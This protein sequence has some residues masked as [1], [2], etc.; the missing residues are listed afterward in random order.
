MSDKDARQ[1][2]LDLLDK[3]AFDPVLNANPDDYTKDKR[4]ELDHAVR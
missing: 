4:N 1:E 2:L 3:K